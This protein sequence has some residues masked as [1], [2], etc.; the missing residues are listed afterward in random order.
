MHNPELGPAPAPVSVPVQPP[1]AT[2]RPQWLPSYIP[3]L[4]GLRGLAVLAV[5]IYH[6]HTRLEGTWI[7]YASRWGWIGV[8]LFFTLSGF[9][10]TS[11]LI[12]ARDKPDFFR[13]FYA[14]RALR[15][16]PVYFLLLAVCYSVP[17]W[18]LGDTWAHQAQWKI[19]LAYIFFVQNLRHVPLPGTLGPTW[20]LAIEEQYYFIWAPIVRFARGR[21]RW[22]LPAAG[23]AML[24]ISPAFRLSHI[25][26][27]NDPPHTLI[28]LDGI[29]M[30]SLLAMAVYGI[31]LTRRKWI[32]IGVTAAVLGF[33]TVGTVFA[34]TSF[35]DTGLAIGFAGVVLTSVAGT[36]ARNPV[37]WLLRRGPLPFY[38]Q[39]S[40]GMY[41]T[42]ILVF[43]YFGNFDARLDDKY[44]VG[45]AGNLAI[46]GLRL[47]A[48]TIAATVLWYGFESQVLK[49]KKYFKS[50]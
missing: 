22:M 12:E 34:G 49:L 1:R 25:H 45:I 4:Q 2:T 40:Y 15:I 42:H 24:A 47:L 50:A 46:V 14:R 36:G 8:N 35:L 48:S 44:H 10:I 7:A 18:F 32:W 6:C 3:E 16:W 20:S 27:M 43:V 38:G 39:I 21:L 17:E 29:A 41:M 5:V 28:H 33:V 13:N 30:G 11:I 37:A 23:V 31:P 26:W 19:I 9:L